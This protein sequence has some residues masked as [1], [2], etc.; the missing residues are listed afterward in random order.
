[1]YIHFSHV[2]YMYST[3]L[4]K[5]LYPIECILQQCQV[6]SNIINKNYIIFFFKFSLLVVLREPCI[7]SNILSTVHI[8]VI[9]VSY[10]S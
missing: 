3:S 4:M 6:I 7:S 2:F 5:V 9:G 1:M 8:N 10:Q